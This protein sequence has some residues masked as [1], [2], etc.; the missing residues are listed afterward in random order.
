MASPATSADVVYTYNLE[1]EGTKDD[2][3]VGLGYLDPYLKDSFVTSVTAP[4]SVDGRD[5][6][7]ATDHAS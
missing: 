2:G 5:H 4:G 6:L 7:F 3:V 1:L